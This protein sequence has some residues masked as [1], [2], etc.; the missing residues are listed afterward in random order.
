MLLLLLLCQ[1]QNAWHSSAQ[2][3]LVTGR[4]SGAERCTFAASATA[5]RR[6][7]MRGVRHLIPCTAGLSVLSWWQH[8]MAL[9]QSHG[10]GP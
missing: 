7:T 8:S 10:W 6:A 9:Q 1:V 4:S 3:T 5:F 2:E